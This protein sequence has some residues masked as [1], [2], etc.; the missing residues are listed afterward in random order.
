MQSFAM[1]LLK[2]SDAFDLLGNRKKTKFKT[3][4]Y[5]FEASCCHV[6]N[7]LSTIKAFPPS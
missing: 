4:E 5:P 7:Y 1:L 2:V 3:T 6:S